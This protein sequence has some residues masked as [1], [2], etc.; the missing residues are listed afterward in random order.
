M[1]DDQMQP[2]QPPTRRRIGPVTA[3]AAGSLTA[4]A[5]GFGGVADAQTTETPSPSPSTS[6]DELCE[7]DEAT[8]DETDAAAG[9][10][11]GSSAA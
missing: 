9:T 1:T 11:E 6:Q 10:A 7:K 4:L 5:L 8:A 3:V 2:E